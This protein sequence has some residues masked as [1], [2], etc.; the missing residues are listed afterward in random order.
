MPLL[1]RALAIDPKNI[2]ALPAKAELASALHDVKTAIATYETDLRPA[3][4]RRR[5]KARRHRSRSAGL[6]ARE[7]GQRSR[8]ALP[9]SDRQLRQPARRAHGVRR[10]PRVEEPTKRAP[11]ASGRRPWARTATTRRRSA[12]LGQAA[13]EANDFNKAID[14]YKRLTEVAANDPRAYLLLGQAYMV[15][16]NWRTGARRVQGVVQHLALRRMRSSDS[17]RPISN[18]ATSPKRSKSTNRSTRTR[19]RSSKRTRA[20]SSRWATPTRARTKCRRR[21][22]RYV[23]FLAFLKPGTQ[24]YTEVQQ[25]IAQ[26]DHPSSTAASR[27]AQTGGVSEPGTEEVTTMLVAYDESLTRHLAGVAH[28]ERPDRVR[29]V[30]RELARARAARRA[31]RYAARDRVGSRARARSRA[32]SNWRNAS[33][34]GSMPARSE[35]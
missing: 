26:I 23:R 9:Q 30:A 21:R 3:D 14:N 10:L 4:E 16:K 1:D 28:V 35:N 32:T 22:P 6:R 2:E 33:R 29:V 15:N 12:R 31:H 34:S 13:A 17:R 24:G 5:Q 18:R 8:R 27:E 19:R 11:C 25:M 20:S 7:A